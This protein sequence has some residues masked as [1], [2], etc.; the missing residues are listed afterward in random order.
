MI[1]PTPAELQTDEHGVCT[2]NFSN[3][4]NHAL[5]M[6]DEDKAA[7]SKRK[8]VPFGFRA[9]PP[10]IAKAGFPVAADFDLPAHL[11]GVRRMIDIQLQR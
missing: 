8:T 2:P 9:P 5:P 4:S 7:L 3:G 6:T 1:V 11:T 10:L